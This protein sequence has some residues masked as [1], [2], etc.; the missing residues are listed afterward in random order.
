MKPRRDITLGEMQE[1]CVAYDC[2]NCDPSLANLCRSMQTEEGEM[3]APKFWDF[4]DPPRFTEAQMAFFRGW[5]GVGARSVRFS[6]GFMLFDQANEYHPAM[7]CKIPIGWD[8]SF[9]KQDERIYLAELL[10]KDGESK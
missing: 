4:T 9:E 1:K 6:D 10:G 5:F 8:A 2:A 3:K 7:V